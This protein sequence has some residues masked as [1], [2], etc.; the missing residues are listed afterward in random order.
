MRK[1][2]ADRMVESATTIPHF[3]VTSKVNVGALMHLKDTLKPLPQYE[4]LTFNHLIMRGVALALRAFSRLN[5]SYRDASIFQ[6][7]DINIGIITAVTDGLLIPVVKNCDQ[8]SLADLTSEARALVQRARS[9]RPKST[10]LV[11][12]TF[13]I[14]NMGMFAVESFTAIINPGN[15][16]ILAVS[17]IEAEPV[18]VNGAIEP[19]KVCRFT[20]SVDH[21]II[22][23]VMA[24]E[25]LTEL[26]RLLEEPVLLLA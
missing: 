5:S 4:G 22:D 23:G 26:K 8:L 2:I 6:P 24:G 1:T 3:Y 17:S 21:R 12:A 15:G 11:G 20:L 13:C 9:G 14:S 16:A 10:D 25:F 19:G 7:Q 18:I